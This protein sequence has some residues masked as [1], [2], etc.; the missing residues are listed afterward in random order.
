M[1]TTTDDPVPSNEQ[2]QLPVTKLHKTFFDDPTLS[3]LT[4]RLSDRTVYV[5]RIILYRGSEYSIKQLAGPFLVSLMRTPLQEGLSL[6]DIKKKESGAKEIELHEDDP[7]A[8]IAL[9]C[10]IYGHSYTEDATQRWNIALQPHAMVFV[11]AEKYQVEALKQDICL[12]IRQIL[13]SAEYLELERDPVHMRVP[14]VS[15]IPCS[16]R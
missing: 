12:N 7:D 3:D 10:F 9:L 5:H 2:T 1:P 14:H 8:M 11:V 4:I 15:S 13:R 16:S 6:A